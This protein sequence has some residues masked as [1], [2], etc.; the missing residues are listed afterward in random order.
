MIV[1]FLNLCL[2]TNLD[3]GDQKQHS[4]GSSSS[5]LSQC[6]SFGILSASK[7]ENDPERGS[8][9]SHKRTHGFLALHVSNC[10]F[11]SQH[12]DPFLNI[13]DCLEH[14]EKN[15][16][17]K[18]FNIQQLCCLPCANILSDPDYLQ[19]WPEQA[20]LCNGYIF[21]SYNL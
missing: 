6:A 14:Q 20:P 11:P 9:L 18:K 1:F 4:T 17:K 2:A 15:S 19:L 5:I 16:E 12:S 13:P 7:A 3:F 21:L 10:I 8:D